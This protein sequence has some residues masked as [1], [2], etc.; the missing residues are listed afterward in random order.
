MTDLFFIEKD[1]ERSESLR[2]LRVAHP[3]R[4]IEVITDD[5]NIA[6]PEFCDGMVPFERAVVFLDPFATG[7]ELGYS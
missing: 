5:C 2:D 1:A 7:G 6:L 4:N 3:D